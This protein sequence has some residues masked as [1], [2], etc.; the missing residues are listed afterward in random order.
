MPSSKPKY[1][2][3]EK[4]WAKHVTPFWPPN[5]LVA[6]S[7]LSR[8]LLMGYSWVIC[9]LLDVG[10]LTQFL[11]AYWYLCSLPATPLLAPKLGTGLL[12]S[13]WFTGGLL[14]SYSPSVSLL[15]SLLRLSLWDLVN[16]DLGLSS[17]NP[18]KVQ[19]YS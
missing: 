7:W 2:S 4:A 15:A 18:G 6:Y 10:R 1:T 16:F 17:E 14:V 5:F 8:G 12:V 19:V 13:C 11:I 3:K 9:R